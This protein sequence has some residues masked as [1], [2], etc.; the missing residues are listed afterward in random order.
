MPQLDTYSILHTY[1]LDNEEY[2]REENIIHN[3]LY[4]NSFPIQTRN[5][6]NPKQNQMRNSQTIIP[7]Q[8]W[9]TFTYIGKETTY[10]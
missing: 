6:P 2:N 10:H 1:Q 7:K 4:N 5:F 3:I 9:A 8:K